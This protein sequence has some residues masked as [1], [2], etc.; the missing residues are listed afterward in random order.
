MA[1]PAVSELNGKLS[2]QGGAVDGAA[3]GAALGSVALPL[4]EAFGLQFDVAGGLGEGRDFA[5]TGAH[6]F[7]RAPS[8]YL[9][10][11]YGSFHRSG[12]RDLW[13]AAAEGELYLG[14]FSFEALVGIES[15]DDIPT[16]TSS[17]RV[18]ERRDDHVFSVASLAFYPL[19]DLRL[20][21]GHR[22]ASEAHLATAEV[23]WRFAGSPVSLYAEGALGERDYERASAGLRIHFGVENDKSL[24][25]RH[26]EDDPRHHLPDFV[27]YSSPR[28]GMPYEPVSDVAGDPLESRVN[29]V[30]LP[31]RDVQSLI[32]PEA[33]TCPGGDPERLLPRTGNSRSGGVIDVGSH[34]WPVGER[35]YVRP[36]LP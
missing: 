36:P 10:G 29:S 15:E 34:P 33:S 17:G 4:G 31:S 8:R 6:F 26:R 19:D 30:S 24:K 3:Q 13:R 21:L 23:E 16:R 11:L 27:A 35:P 5:G 18:V 1:E 12:E 7:H 22:Y 20:A 14:P 25:R 9:L 2:V 28:C 32:S